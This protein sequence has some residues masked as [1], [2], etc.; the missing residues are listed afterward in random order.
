[1][2]V[3]YGWFSQ[4]YQ[5]RIT[6][7]E[8]LAFKVKEERRQLK[9]DYDSKIASLIRPNEAEELKLLSRNTDR[10]EQ[11]CAEREATVADLSNLGHIRQKLIKK[12]YGLVLQVKQLS[13]YRPGML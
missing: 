1:M 4:I 10:K 5:S 7:L 8:R 2:K 11:S 6:Q 3:E 9:A 12:A 13:K